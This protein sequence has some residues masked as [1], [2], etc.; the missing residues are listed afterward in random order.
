MEVVRL[1]VRALRGARRRADGGRERVPVWP[2]LL[3]WC[4]RRRRGRSGLAR[5]PGMKREGKNTQT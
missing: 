5:A 1:L 2:V 3:L 4:G